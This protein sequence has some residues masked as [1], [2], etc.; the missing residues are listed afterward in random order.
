M[1]TWKLFFP[2]GDIKAE[3]MSAP[4]N[5]FLRTLFGFGVVRSSYDEELGRI[6]FSS[7]HSSVEERR[8]KIQEIRSFSTPPA[9]MLVVVCWAYIL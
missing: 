9:G 4:W 5:N 2:D 6:S 7:I 8:R 3:M 1:M